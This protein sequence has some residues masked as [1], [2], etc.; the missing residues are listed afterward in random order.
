MLLIEVIIFNFYLL[1]KIKLFKKKFE[2]K[3]I[4]ITRITRIFYFNNLERILK[5]ISR[6]IKLFKKS[7]NKNNFMITG[8]Y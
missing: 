3:T 2:Q 7:L 4:M 5:P 1:N 8:N 6:Y